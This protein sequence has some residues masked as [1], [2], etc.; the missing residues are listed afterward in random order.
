MGLNVGAGAKQ[1]PPADYSMLLEMKRRRLIY[2]GVPV[3]TGLMGF[4]NGQV[5]PVTSDRP[6]QRGFEEGPV[7]PRLHLRGALKNFIKF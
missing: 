4:D 6:F 3:K 1:G 7:T 5:R 2:L